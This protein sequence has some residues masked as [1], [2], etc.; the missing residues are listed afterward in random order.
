MTRGYATTQAEFGTL[1]RELLSTRA[2]YESMRIGGA[3]FGDRAEMLDRLHT[4]RANMSM[5]RKTM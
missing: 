2:Q 4:L 5:V 3:G 1:F